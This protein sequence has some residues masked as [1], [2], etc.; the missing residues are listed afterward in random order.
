MNG[1]KTTSEISYPLEPF[2]TKVVEKIKITTV[3]ERLKFM[4]EAHYNLFLLKAENVMIDLLTDS[5]TGAMSD[6]QTSCLLTGDESYAGSKSFYRFEEVL[7]DLTNFKHIFPVHQGR[8]AEK[9]LFNFLCK[10]NKF[11]LSNGLFDT[12]R[13]NIE[14]YGTIGIDLCLE[15]DSQNLFPFKGNIC[16]TKLKNELESK[17]S[18]ISFVLLTITCNSFGGQPVSMENIMNTKDLCDKYGIPLVIDA[19]RFAENAY[20]IKLREK[21]F[22]KMSIKEIVR[23]MF[24]NADFMTFS[25]KKDGIAHIGGCLALNDSELAEKLESFLILT[26]GF[27]TYGGMAGRDMDAIAQGLTEVIDEGYLKHRIESCKYLG[28]KLRQIGIELILPTGGHAVYIDAKKFLPHIDSLHYPAQALAVALYVAGGIRSVEIGTFM[29]GRKPN[30]SEEPAKKEL[31]RLALP[32]RVYNQNHFDYI[33]KVFKEISM[34]KKTING[35]QIV[36]ESKHLRHFSSHLKP[37]DF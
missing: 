26:E 23:K 9:I 36:K 34:Q 11:V 25:A 17:S 1:F 12:T 8:A 6:E 28:D 32:R 3:E 14:Y 13:G 29:F 4:E 19:C 7:K 22:E 10:P 31:L 27:K 33:A 18:E 20:F 24:S 15:L 5:G 16:M 2:R 35:F 30:G 37:V 21:A